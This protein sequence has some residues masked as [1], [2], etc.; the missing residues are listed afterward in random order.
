MAWRR[1]V[2]LAGSLAAIAAAA[3]LAPGC[4]RGRDAAG[5]R[6]TLSVTGALGAGDTAGYARALAPRAFHFPADH[7]PHPGFR[8]EWWYFTG[9]LV[10]DDGRVFGYELTFFRTALSAGSAP[11]ASDW[12]AREVYMAHFAITDS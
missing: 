12:G 6:A 2:A 10:G 3:A 11:R 7:G 5:V 4:G 9:N 8:N 1:R